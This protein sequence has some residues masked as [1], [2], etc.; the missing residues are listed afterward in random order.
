[1]L[2]NPIINKLQQLR[3]HTMAKGFKEQLEQ[4]IMTELSFEDRLGLLVDME[5]TERQNRR[6]QSRLKKAKL[7]QSACLED[8]DYSSQRNLDKS[9]LATLSSCQWVSSHHNV[10]I[11]GPC[12]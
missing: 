2:I 8:I 4:P 10:L 6:F 3:L 7:Q 1:M 12:G 11:V 5:V 9:L